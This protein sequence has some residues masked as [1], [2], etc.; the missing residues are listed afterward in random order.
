M[1]YDIYYK[2]SETNHEWHY[3]TTVSDTIVKNKRGAVTVAIARWKEIQH[4]WPL[5]KVWRP[6]EIFIVC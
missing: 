5:P 4:S 6:D 2:W 1:Q 3:F